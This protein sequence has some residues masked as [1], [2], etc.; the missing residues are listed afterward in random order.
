MKLHTKLAVALICLSFSAGAQIR[1]NPNTKDLT[2]LVD[3]YICVEKVTTLDAGAGF[4]AYDWYSEKNPTVS[5]SK[6]QTLKNVGVGEY[7]VILTAVNGCK[8]RQKVNVYA[9][10]VPEISEIIIK[11]YTVQI[12]ATKGNLPYMY[13]LDGVNYQASNLFVNVGPGNY[14]AYVIS[15]D[16]CVPDT[17]EFIIIMYNVLTPNDDGYNDVLDMSLLNTKVDV[18]FQIHDRNGVKVFEGDNNNKYIWNGKLNG[19][20]LPTSSYWYLLEWKDFINTAAIRQTGWILL[21]NRN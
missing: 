10:E 8:Y 12:I 4:S 5:L 11:D 16:N 13:S 1:N 2:L 21:K 7:L 18:K 14:K 3:Q 6:T 17:K 15:K 20:P 19:R 9:V